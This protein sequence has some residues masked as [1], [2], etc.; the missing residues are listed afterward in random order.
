MELYYDFNKD[1]KEVKNIFIEE[2]LSEE[3]KE[4][5]LEPLLYDIKV[6][7]TNHAYH[8][9]HDRDIDWEDDIETLLLLAGND[10]L[11]VKNKEKV[12]I[13]TKDF[14]FVVIG[15]IHYQDGNLALIIHTI[16]KI[17]QEGKE[18]LIELK[19]IGIKDVDKIIEVNYTNNNTAVVA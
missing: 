9:M 18:G 6:C 3:E 5:G 12:A 19:K 14:T 16:I 13:A 10:L 8:R 2:K 7:F 4:E 1:F 11:T 17:E 15:H